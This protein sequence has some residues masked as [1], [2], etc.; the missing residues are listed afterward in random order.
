MN[1]VHLRVRGSG[2]VKH[3][4]TD[5]KGLRKKKGRGTCE[6][7]MQKHICS[8]REKECTVILVCMSISAN[9]LLLVNTMHYAMPAFLVT[10]FLS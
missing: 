5:R 1:Y 2:F 8:F 9:E 3:L 7:K 6:C 10:V 4:H